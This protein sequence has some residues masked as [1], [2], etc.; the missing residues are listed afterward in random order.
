MLRIPIDRRVSVG[1]AILCFLAFIFSFWNLTFAGFFV[2]LLIGHLT[3]FRDPNR[4]PSPGNGPVSPADGTV[5]HISTEYEP[6]FLKEQAVRIGIFLSVFNVHVNRSPVEGEVT[7]LQY[8]PG[9]F[10]NALSKESVVQNES[11]WIG[12]RNK[13]QSAFVRQIAGTIARRIHCDVSV[14]AR[15]KRGQKFGIICYGSRVECWIPQR[16]F[17]PRISLGE[18]VKA[19]KTLL[20]EWES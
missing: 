12:L 20:G 19:G 9:R 5:V 7:Y 14:A 15:L 11:N 3:F 4:T 18:R 2:L 10:L 16:M 17:Q 8:E 1:A 6:R 13:N